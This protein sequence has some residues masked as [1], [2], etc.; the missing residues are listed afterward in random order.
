[1]PCPMQ[2]KPGAFMVVEKIT[3]VTKIASGQQ[4][5]AISAV[6]ALDKE[7]I[8]LVLA[9]A[10]LDDVARM[11]DGS[12]G[13]HRYLGLLTARLVEL[14]GQISKGMADDGQVYADAMRLQRQRL[15]QDP[16]SRHDLAMHPRTYGRPSN[17]LITDAD[18]WVAPMVEAEMELMS[19]DDL[20]TLRH[21]VIMRVGRQHDIHPD[22]RPLL[23]RLATDDRTLACLAT[24]E[25]GQARGRE[26]NRS[27]LLA[28][29]AGPFIDVVMSDADDGIELEAAAWDFV[30]RRLAQAGARSSSQQ[31]VQSVRETSSLL[32]LID[33]SRA[34]AA[35]QSQAQS[36]AGL[37][38]RSAIAEFVLSNLILLATNPDAV[39]AKGQLEIG[40]FVRRD[41]VGR[42]PVDIP[43]AAFETWA[44]ER[45]CRHL[46][47]D[48][49]LLTLLADYDRHGLPPMP[50]M[51]DHDVMDQAIRH[52]AEIEQHTLGKMAIQAINGGWYLGDWAGAA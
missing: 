48:L 41:F 6:G 31:L 23:L 43:K 1:M 32:A 46:L 7:T 36:H 5:N 30:Q 18:D 25:Q 28:A 10:G 47:L 33:T 9:S 42:S 39:L 21:H 8:E 3:E 52:L 15:E 17:L 12:A 24:L 14:G 19:A 45:S 29:V 51:S 34:L 50:P 44:A 11:L 16:G 2:G 38:T 37:A 26:P 27:Y 20:A 13:Y 40:A 4:E 22:F 35:R 49:V